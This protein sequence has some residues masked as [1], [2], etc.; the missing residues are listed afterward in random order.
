[1]GCEPITFQIFFSWL[2]AVLEIESAG[3]WAAPPQ[4]HYSADSGS[5]L[6]N[7][8]RLFWDNLSSFFYSVRKWRC[9]IHLSL[10]PMIITLTWFLEQSEAF[11]NKHTNWPLSPCICRAKMRA[12]RSLALVRSMSCCSACRTLSIIKDKGVSRA[13][14]DTNTLTQTTSTTI[15]VIKGSSCSLKWKCFNS[16]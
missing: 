9:A 4:D 13:G 8:Q 3:L 16:M 7:R 2:T 6:H 1:M 11:P 14:A 10:Q 5:E 12:D 15:R